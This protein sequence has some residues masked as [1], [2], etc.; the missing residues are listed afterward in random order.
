MP[1]RIAAA[2]AACLV[3][4]SI[5][6]ATV[7]EAADRP[8]A[9]GSWAMAPQSKDANGDG[10]IDGDGGVPAR[11][12]LSLSPSATMIGA[13][14]YVAQPN[15]RLI[16]GSLSW[17]LGNTFSVVLNAC[18]SQGDSYSWAVTGATTVRT[19]PKPMKKCTSSVMLPEGTYSFALTVKSGRS[20]VKQTM[21]GTVNNYVMV[22]MGD[23]YAS[24]EGNPRNIDAYLE[25]AGL[26]SSFTPYW[27]DSACARSTHS[28]PARAAL[29]LEKSSPYFSVT[30]IDVSCSGAT[31]NAGVLGPQ[32]RARQTASQVEQARALAAG[33]RI[34][35][36]TLSVGGND[37]GFGAILQAC[38]L[39]ANCPT[40]PSSTPPL[41]GYPSTQAGAQANLAALPAKYA[42]V[43]AALA[44]L[45]PGAP[46]F[47][48]M[49]PD[50]TRDANGAPCTYLTMSQSDFAWARATLLV[51]DPQSPYSYVTTSGATVPMAL[52]AGTLNSQIAATAGALGWSDIA[53]TWG[54]S[55]NSEVGHGVCAGS[56]AWTF[57]LISLG[58]LAAAAFHPNPKGLEVMGKAIAAEVGTRLR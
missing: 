18:G 48:T 9:K 52:P 47:P 56:Q 6:T 24:G 10:F 26:F 36:I 21:R 2:L 8:I 3:L 40:Q 30:L 32:A 13:G 41:K 35:A 49:Y 43:N 37:I 38:A 50:I 39:Q 25:Q 22:S 57:G 29:E 45:A 17:Y 14:N 4:A 53:G 16:N 27:D 20:T 58:P 34:D 33:Q 11:G 28:A 7:A 44:G 46:I 42:A 23:S 12:A 19:P 55:G 15:E 5:G 51:P 54:A 31:I 1:R